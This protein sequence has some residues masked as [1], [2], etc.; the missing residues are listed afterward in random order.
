VLNYCKCLFISLLI[1]V[2]G[3][4]NKPNLQ[5]NPATDFQ[6]SGI[7]NFVSEDQQSLLRMQ[8]MLNFVP[9]VP[10]E[11]FSMMKQ[12]RINARH[13]NSEQKILRDLV[14]GLLTVAPK[15]LY[16]EKNESKVSID[17]GVAGYHTFNILQMSEILM[18]G[19]EI[20]AFAGWKNKDLIIQMSFGSSYQL[21]EKFTLLDNNR[22][23]ET[24]ELEISHRKKS[25]THK[26]Y[27]TRH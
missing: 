21:T 19:F 23:L 24:I 13:W 11:R 22:L 10:S 7:W 4:S 16:F 2:A 15:E 25:I 3:C 20:K 5:D 17:F 26:R 8:N 6:F 27:F 9:P 12:E 18:D 14:V 1:I